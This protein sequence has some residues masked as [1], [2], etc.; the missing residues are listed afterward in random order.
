[1]AQ[2]IQSNNAVDP[3][4]QWKL[5]AAGTA[6]GVIGIGALGEGVGQ[7]RQGLRNARE[8]RTFKRAEKS[9]NSML[10][11]SALNMMHDQMYNNPR[12]ADYKQ[13][14]DSAMSKDSVMKRAW[15]NLDP[16]VPG[17]MGRK[18]YTRLAQEQLASQG[19]H[20]IQ[21]ETAQRHLDMVAGKASPY[22]NP[23]HNP[24]KAGIMKRMMNMA[25]KR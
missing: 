22:M 1:M 4:A 6:A 10:D 2:Q 17:G 16:S 9:Y 19:Y 15:N 3:E 7:A 5:V 13:A 21:R 20:P 18:D 11:K 24:K 12:T 14:Y 8:N 25:L 23:A